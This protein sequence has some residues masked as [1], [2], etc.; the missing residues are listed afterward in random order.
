M[1]AAVPQHRSP[2]VTDSAVLVTQ[3]SCD[4]P[5]AADLLA[6]GSGEAWMLSVQPAR[7][8]VSRTSTASA[9]ATSTHDAP[10]L[11]AVRALAPGTDLYAVRAVAA[12]VGALASVGDHAFHSSLAAALAANV[13]FSPNAVS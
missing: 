9:V 2:T 13:F 11:A 5:E 7:S 8:V 1:T 10:L 6:D 3:G 12:A 4:T